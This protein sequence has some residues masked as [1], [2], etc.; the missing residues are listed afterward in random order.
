MSESG[1]TVRVCTCKNKCYDA[2]VQFIKMATFKAAKSSSLQRCA[3]ATASPSAARAVASAS[4]AAARVR[5]AL[6]SF[7]FAASNCNVK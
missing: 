2:N 1:A 3:S 5:V 7:T 6:D 4:C